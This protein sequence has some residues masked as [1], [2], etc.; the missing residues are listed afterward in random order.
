MGYCDKSKEG[1]DKGKFLP[2]NLKA[3]Q[4]LMKY[5]WISVCGT[6]N[7]HHRFYIFPSFQNLYLHVFFVLTRSHSFSRFR[8]NECW[9][10]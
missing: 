10:D 4:L 7:I 8:K 9:E 3:K 1:V 6:L 5:G 2:E